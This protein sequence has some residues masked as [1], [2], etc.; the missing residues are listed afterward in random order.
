MEHIKCPVCGNQQKLQYKLKFSVY[1]CPQCGLF[2]SDANF[3]FSFQ[4]SLELNSREVGLKTLRFGNFHSII[5]E[6]KALKGK[7][8]E[9]MHGLE[10]GVGNGWWLKVCKENGIACTGIEPEKVHQDYH[11]ENG[12]EVFYGFY[13][14]PHVK[15]ENGYD[16]IIFNDVFEHIRDLDELIAALKEDLADDGLLIINIPQSDGFFYRTGTLLNKLG[17]SSYLTRLWQ[18]NFHSP[19]MNYFNRHNLS[20]LLKH[21]GFDKSNDFKLDSLDFKTLKERIKADADIS[22][23]KAAILTTGLRLLKP[24]IA[25][26]KPDI[27]VFFFKK[28]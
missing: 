13:P 9:K 5:K 3:D 11:R 22:K 18:F 27:R 8:F 28:Q 4:S 6:L 10:I 1:K 19:H 12:L 14:D 26:S 15:R 16:F 24:V 7:D 23:L 2:T 25:S 20:L 17:I 21:H